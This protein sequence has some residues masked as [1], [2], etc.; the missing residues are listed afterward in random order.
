MA[1]AYAGQYVETENFVYL[2]VILFLVE[3]LLFL[4]YYVVRWMDQESE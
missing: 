4:R 1:I 2:Q 3:L